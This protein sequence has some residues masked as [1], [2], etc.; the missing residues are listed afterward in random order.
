MIVTASNRLLLGP[1]V[2]LAVVEA[3]V[4]GAGVFGIKPSEISLLP[5]GGL[6]PALRLRH[7]AMLS[8]Q[9]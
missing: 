7:H 5:D 4:L 2:E 9:E 8:C 1:L 6:K 3:L